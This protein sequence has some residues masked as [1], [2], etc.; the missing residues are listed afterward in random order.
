VEKML[1]AL[2]ILPGKTAA[3]RAFLKEL[4]GPRKEQFAVS[5]RRLGVVEEVW[6]IQAGAQGDLLVAYGAAPNLANAFQQFAAS[7]DD[8]DQW[9]KTRLGEVTGADLNVPPTAPMSEILS[10]YHA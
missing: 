3:A 2:P 1:F 9:F 6:A 10:D 8:F 5:E 7:K 4:E